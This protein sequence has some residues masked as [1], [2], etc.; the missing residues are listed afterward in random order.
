MIG[1]AGFCGSLSHP[2]GDSG[3]DEFDGGP[4]ASAHT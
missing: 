2:C 1:R 4:E 3:T